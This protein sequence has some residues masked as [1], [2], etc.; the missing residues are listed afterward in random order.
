M[1][2]QPINLPIYTFTL[3][4]RRAFRLSSFPGDDIGQQ[5]QNLDTTNTFILFLGGG[6]GGGLGALLLTHQQEC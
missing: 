4:P 5:A 6:G 3:V 2:N 1:V